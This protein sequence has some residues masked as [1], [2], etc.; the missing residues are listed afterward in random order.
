MAVRTR[1]QG[2]PIVHWLVPSFDAA[3]RALESGSFDNSEP[4][5]YRIIAVYSV[6]V[7]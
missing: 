7:A 3:V 4:G 2:C 6:D 1:D 5:P